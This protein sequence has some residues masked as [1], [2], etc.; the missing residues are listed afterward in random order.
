[1]TEAC[2]LAVTVRR[3]EKG[4]LYYDRDVYAGQD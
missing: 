4:G 3:S 1:L 2:E